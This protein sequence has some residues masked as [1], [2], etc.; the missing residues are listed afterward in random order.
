MS[1]KSKTDSSIKK[2][3]S[4]ESSNKKELLGNSQIITKEEELPKEESKDINK[5]KGEIYEKIEKIRE[6]LNKRL[7]DALE[8]TLEE[9][10]T[11]KNPLEE[12]QKLLKVDS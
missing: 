10:Q 9:L 12:L 7:A 1:E 3:E 2:S 4:K 11:K 6:K 8:I 5:K